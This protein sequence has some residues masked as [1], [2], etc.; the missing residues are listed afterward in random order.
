MPPVSPA[1]GGR[2]DASAA[3]SAASAAIPSVDLRA[4]SVAA[5]SYVH[6]G[7]AL[8]TG[9]HSHG[10]HQLEYTLTGALAVTSRRARFVCPPHQAVWIPAG[11]EHRSALGAGRT[12]SVFLSP[13]LVAGRAAAD[14]LAGDVLVLR[15]TPLLREMVLHAVRWP[16]T[17]TGDDDPVAGPY[18]EAL[19]ALVLDWVD[20]Q[21]PWSLPESG[22]PLVAAAMS[23]TRA[24]LAGAR[25]RTV[26]RC[27]GVSERSL[28]RLFAA[29]VGITWH[30]YLSRARLLHAMTRL[31]T[32]DDGV[33]RIA[34]EVG[35]DSA[36]S[37]TRALRSWTGATPAQYR[38][39]AREESNRA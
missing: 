29:D 31:A 36:T 19:S 14:D 38:A 32:S 22:H 30:A 10:L 34:A 23:A 6:D 24:D 37:L 4:G 13:D 9:W 39:R 27:V 5:G 12:V 26:A 8:D 2:V 16:I 20:E 21:G 28:R 11:A 35:Y 7:V 33:L 15:A 1:S 25:P 18:F 17:R 3:E